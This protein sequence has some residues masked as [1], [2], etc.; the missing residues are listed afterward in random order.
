M[1]AAFIHDHN[2]V[3]NQ[4][5]GLYYDGSGGVFTKDLWE[6]YLVIF[7]ELK[8]IG[9]GIDQLPNKLILS[10]YE[11]VSFSLVYNAHSFKNRVFD[12]K[13]IVNEIRESIVDVDFVIIRLPSFLGSIA[14]ELCLEL[15][16]KY[17]VEV[18]G[19]PYEAYK[20]H[21]TLLGK[22]VAPFEMLKLKS[23]I[24]KANNVIYVTQSKLQ[25]RY[26][27]NNNSIGISN[28]QLKN[29]LSKDK[30]NT[31]YLEN[32]SP[33]FKIGLIGT[34]HVKYKGHFELLK[35]LKDLRD[36]GVNNIKVY[37]V[38]TGDPNW[39]I[40]LAKEMGL[41]DNI[42]IL[43]TLKAGENGIIPFLD[44]IDCYVH[45]SLT[46]GLPRVVI[47]AMSRGKI[48][49]TSDAGGVR[50]LIKDSYIHKAGDWNM[51]KKQLDLVMKLS[52]EEQSIIG[53]EN[54][55]K[56]RDYLEDILQNKRINF[57]KKLL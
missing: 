40:S 9:R 55:E 5:N 56:S 21:G 38:G 8:I 4:L 13:R 16:K 47:E 10:S 44:S 34:F 52:K 26:P 1:K 6:R 46:E 19:D 57:I 39:V 28:V 51:L 27:N 7:D 12:R 43:G 41:L 22:V 54:L 20:F 2:F 50:E 37:F 18:V 25:E 23:I 14:F 53:L 35:A 17:I 48:C 32:N 49:L 30:V 3:L 36:Q 33:F 42:V 29:I 11:N 45:P 31:Y 24:N 15:N